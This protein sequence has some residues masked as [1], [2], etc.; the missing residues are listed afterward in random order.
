MSARRAT[1]RVR[2]VGTY[3]WRVARGDQF[4]E[5]AAMIG[6]MS[7]HVFEGPPREIVG[8]RENG[9]GRITGL[10]ATYGVGETVTVRLRKDGSYSVSFGLRLTTKAGK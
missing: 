7:G 8:S 1:K 2:R 6:Q 10:K 9:G 4:D 3:R 5:L